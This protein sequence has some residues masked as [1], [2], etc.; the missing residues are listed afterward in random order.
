MVEQDISKL[1]VVCY[2]LS[3]EDMISALLGRITKRG[4]YPIGEWLISNLAN[5][6]PN[7]LD[8]ASQKFR[9]D[10]SGVISSAV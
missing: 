7:L 1:I 4:N 10:F 8:L 3:I 2:L 9:T 6:E 5:L